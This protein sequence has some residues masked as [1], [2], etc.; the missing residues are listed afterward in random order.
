MQGVAAAAPKVAA[1]GLY[2]ALQRG[3]RDHSVFL[4][5]PCSS[6]K[7]LIDKK[8]ANSPSIRISFRRTT[9]SMHRQVLVLLLITFAHFP[10]LYR[11]FPISH[12]YY[13]SKLLFCPDAS[14]QAR[15]L[16]RNEVHNT[17]QYNDCIA[18]LQ[19]RG[20]PKGLL[21]FSIYDETPHKVR[22]QASE[23][24]LQPCD[25]LSQ[26][27]APTG[28]SAQ[29][30]PLS[31]SHI[32]PPPIIFSSSPPVLQP[33]TAMDVDPSPSQEASAPRIDWAAI[34]PPPII[35]RAPLPP[36]PHIR[37]APARCYATGTYPG[38]AAHPSTSTQAPQ[39]K[40]HC[41]SVAEGKTSVQVLFNE[42]K[43]DLDNIMG[44]TFE[45]ESLSSPPATSEWSKW[46]NFWWCHLC[47]KN[48][49]GPSYYTCPR[50]RWRVA[51]SI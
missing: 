17:E 33:T 39:I 13:L 30:K 45:T 4:F 36:I 20:F 34:P 23:D 38:T 18:P 48:F 7:G 22:S 31:P 42:F 10:Q 47:G 12:S 16:L 8:P 14:S 41:C 6:L 44:K 51:V 37:S 49:Q 26:V 24:T 3:R 43:R 40:Q 19:G 29:P 11:V 25:S 15:I 2:K 5:P 35:T 1:V 32:P 28:A 50:C 27:S 9:S 21:R 46:R